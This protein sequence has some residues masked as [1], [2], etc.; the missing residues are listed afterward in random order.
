LV[1][2]RESQ[3]RLPALVISSSEDE[4]RDLGKK[5]AQLLERGSIVA[6]NGPLGAG[7]TCFAKGLARGLGIADEL[8]SPSYAIIAEYDGFISGAGIKLYHID[9]YRLGGSEDFIG[10]GGEELVFGEGISVIEWGERLP[11]FVMQK[12]ISVDFEIINDNERR[13][14]L[15]RRY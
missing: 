13:I 11:D 14:A 6:L 5:F 3:V 12:A 2:D 1:Q 7:K 9:A 15:Y 10:L 4:T 8:T